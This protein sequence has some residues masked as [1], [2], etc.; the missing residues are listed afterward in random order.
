MSIRW[1]LLLLLL[2]IALVPLAVVGWHAKSTIRSLGTKIAAQE[3]ETLTRELT[4]RLRVTVE[5][6]ADLIRA[7]KT[8]VELAL[9]RIATEAEARLVLR[10]PTGAPVYF[11]HQFDGVGRVPPGLHPSDKHKRIGADGTPEPK[12]ISLEAVNV[13]LAPGVAAGTVSDD[14][15]RLAT[16]LP[17]YQNLYAKQPDLLFWM[18]TALESGVHVSFPGHGG[19]PEGYDPRY[20]PWYE[21]AK[22]TGERRWSA[23]IVDATTRRL[24]LT[25]SMPVKGADGAFAGVTALDV[26]ILDILERVAQG[27]ATLTEAETFLVDHAARGGGG[28]GTGV[29]VIAHRSYEA[30]DWRAAIEMN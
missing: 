9:E 10:E 29:W 23:P 16:M 3:R 13:I 30:S 6:R 15:G 28:V 21:L 11:A 12:P 18:Y 4:E 24:I 26:Q 19:Y 22:Q 17:A 25:L 27:P 8:L 7:Q 2:G 5:D 14:I 1:K 20:R